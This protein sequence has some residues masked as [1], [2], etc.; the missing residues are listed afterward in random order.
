MT[1]LGLAIAAAAALIAA[2][3]AALAQRAGG[4]GQP[5]APA[6]AAGAKPDAKAL[7]ANRDKGLKE[8]PGVLAASPAAQSCQVADALYKGQGD[9]KD[10]N[11]KSIGKITIYE[12]ACKTGPGYLLIKRAAA[13]QALNCIIAQSGQTKC[14]LPANQDAKAALAPYVQQAG[15]TCAIS[16]IRYAGSAPAEGQ[17]FYEI[18]CA[19]PQLG[20]LL[21]VSSKGAAPVVNDCLGLLGGA[22]ECKL[23]TRQQ[24]TASFQPL[25]ARSGKACQVSDFRSIGRAKDGGDTFTE[26]ACGATPGF[27]LVQDA[28]GGFKSAVDCTKAAVI[29]GGCKLTDVT[30]AKT[31]EA[32]AYTKLAAKA[33]FPCQVKEYRYIGQDAQNR[34]VVE[35]S[36][37]DRPDGGLALFSETGK[38]VVV[39]CVRARGIGDTTCKLS[40][41]AVV[42]PRYTEALAAKGRGTCKVS[43]AQYL[44]RTQG[45]V[46]YV[47]TA[48]ADGAPGWVIGFQEGTTTVGDLLT[49]RQ[50]TN[51]GLPCKLPTNTAGNK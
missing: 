24:I 23:T 30:V 9:E 10:A 32:G 43:G 3:H 5:A 27:V 19:A 48:C 38:S 11:G 28:S 34:E 40:D 46:D 51:S 17:D 42:Y 14:E 45:G 35:L 39:D 15:R 13:T 36:C 33:G 26:I 49:C 37:K 20:F 41:P 4:G 1:R 6:A 18:G 31:E 25:V 29:G 44:G 12:V 2:P 21:G 16:D 47:E 8:A 7:A 22:Q 50:A